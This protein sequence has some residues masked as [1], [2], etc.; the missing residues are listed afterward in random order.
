[1]ENRLVT[2]TGRG[3]IRIVAVANDGGVS[4]EERGSRDAMW[5]T[6][7]QGHG[8][9]TSSRV[10][11]SAALLAD[12]EDVP[13]ATTSPPLFLGPGLPHYALWSPRGKRL[14]YVVPDGRSLVLKVWTPRDS[15]ATALTAG[16]PIFPAWHPDEDIVFVHHGTALQRYDLE[17]GEQLVFS[18]SAAGFRTPALSPDGARLAWAEVRDGSVLVLESPAAR[19]EP[20]VLR[21]FG[22]GVVLFYAATGRLLASVGSSPESLAF[23][24][25]VDV[26]TGRQLIRSVMTAAWCAPDGSKIA[27][28]HPSFIGDGRYQAKLWDASGRTLAATEPFVPSVHAGTMVSFFDQYQLSHPLWSADS[29]W[30]AFS[31][32][33]ATEGPHPAFHDGIEDYVWLWDTAQREIH[34]RIAPGSTAAFER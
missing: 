15:G 7:R 21:S 30:F 25:I 31:G 33:F 20:R 2:T 1:M 18:Q 4:V 6:W 28:L 27:T 14:A 8:T 11:D 26:E 16:A 19:A 9:L 22:A 3:A 5:A 13:G 24:A 34:R 12:G 17:S 29:R 10:G 23:S 32:R